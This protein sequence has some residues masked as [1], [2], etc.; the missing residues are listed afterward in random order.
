MGY[1]AY[2]KG[3]T[4]LLTAILGMVER[5]GV[6]AELADQWGETFTDQTV[7][8]VCSNTAKAWRFVGE[9]YEIAATF[10]GAGMPGGFH[11]AAAEVYERLEAFKDQ[12]E[13][14]PIESVLEVLLKD[15]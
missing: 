8:R 12:T 5:E 13:P 4:A 14:P 1:A 15:D 2:T 6:R 3:T 7:R 9:M 10:E 11:R